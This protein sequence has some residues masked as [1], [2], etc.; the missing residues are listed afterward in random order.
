MRWTFAFALAVLG[1]VG[2]SA[3]D[4]IP[5]TPLAAVKSLRCTFQRQ[6]VG[7]WRQD[8]TAQVTER[9]AS[10]VLR[11]VS[12]DT[13]TGTAQLM[14][15]QVGT[16]VTVR[17]AEGYL[18]FMQSFRTGPLYVTTVFAATPRAGRFKAV[19]SRHELFAVPLAGATSSPEQYYGEC[20]VR[21]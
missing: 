5:P 8:G 19:H 3:Q 13:E 12:I 10:L 16:D 7:A 9:A 21:P 15:G 2:G 17:A 14:S 6:S 18:H 11:F 20:E 4:A 1:S